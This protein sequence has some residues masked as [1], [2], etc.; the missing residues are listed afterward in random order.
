MRILPLLLPLLVLLPTSHAAAPAGDV[1]V[2]PGDSAIL[3]HV[4]YSD[5]LASTKFGFT[6]FAGLGGDATQ[7]LEAGALC[8]EWH[9]AFQ[10]LLV[11]AREQDD[12][13]EATLFVT[14]AVGTASPERV[15]PGYVFD[16]FGGPTAFDGRF[17]V[18]DDLVGG[19]SILVSVTVR[20]LPLAGVNPALVRVTPEA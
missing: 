10:Q 14:N 5:G 3:L 8:T 17:T 7:R 12:A 1:Y 6:Q 20:G 4:R 2:L 16:A 11:L 9:G 18:C 13:V 15:G 19:G